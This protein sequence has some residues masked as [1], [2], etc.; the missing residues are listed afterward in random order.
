M[1]NDLICVGAIIEFKDR[2]PLWRAIVGAVYPTEILLT[3][4]STAKQERLSTDLLLERIDLGTAKFL[5]CF[6]DFNDV[7]FADL[8]KE[9]QAEVVRRRKYVEHLREKGFLVITDKATR[10]IADFAKSLNEK[11]KHWQTVRSWFKSYFENN[12]S[13]TKLYPRDRFKGRRESR[14]EEFVIKTIEKEMPRFGKQ[15]QPRMSSILS[16][17]QAEVKKYNLKNPLNVLKVPVGNSY[18]APELRTSLCS[19]VFCTKVKRFDSTT[20]I[21]ISIKAEEETCG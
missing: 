9:E 3:D 16:N 11:P 13:L 10:A 14:I 4:L 2:S 1:S 18:S 6:T 7:Q 19:K 8:T 21:M 20:T 5:S 17:V 15:S 12:R